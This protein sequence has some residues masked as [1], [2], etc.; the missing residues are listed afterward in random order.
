MEGENSYWRNFPP[1]KPTTY[2]RTAKT[3]DP[4]VLA[5][6]NQETSHS[7]RHGQPSE[8][9]SHL[10]EF[11]PDQ[12]RYCFSKQGETLRFLGL[13]FAR[14]R[15]LLGLEK[16]MVWGEQA[17]RPLTKEIGT[18]LSTSLAIWKIIAQLIVKTCVTSFIEHHRRHGSNRYC[19][20]TSRSS[21]PNFILSP[22][23]NQFRASND[24][25]DLLALT[26]RRTAGRY[27]AENAARPR[28]DISSRRLLAKDRTAATSRDPR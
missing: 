12:D 1:V 23:Y 16:V 10:I 7:A 6:E 26:A 20:E 25:I 24:K 5:R 11:A 17:R 13:P 4:P 8:T 18:R 15:S 21:T 27:R 22:I 9:A 2:N 14:V 19:D 28:D 3:E